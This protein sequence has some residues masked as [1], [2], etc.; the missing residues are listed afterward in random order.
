MEEMIHC[1]HSTKNGLTN[2]SSVHYLRKK[3][4]HELRELG[5][6]VRD[7]M[8]RDGVVEKPTGKEG[9]SSLRLRGMAPDGCV[10]CV[11]CHRLELPVNCCSQHNPQRLCCEP[12]S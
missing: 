3:D 12:R 4:S 7:S 1:P 9:T 2:H 8:E 10:P 6:G 5:R 11:W